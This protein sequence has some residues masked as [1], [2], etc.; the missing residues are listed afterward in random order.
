MIR[1]G[2]LSIFV[3]V[4]LV[5]VGIVGV[6]FAF[7]G[8][9]SVFEE[10]YPENVERVY[11]LV[12]NCLEDSGRQALEKLGGQG[13]E[14]F[15]TILAVEGNEFVP[16][17]FLSSPLLRLNSD[18]GDL[19]FGLALEST[20]IFE[21]CIESIEANFPENLDFDLSEGFSFVSEVNEDHVE[22]KIDG[23]V[24]V[25]DGEIFFEREGIN[26][27][28]D[29]YI[30][31]MVK[32]RDEFLEASGDQVGINLELVAD[33]A[34]KYNFDFRMVADED[35]NILII[36]DSLEGNVPRNFTFGVV[37]E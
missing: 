9:T 22:F 33:L 7:S 16:I 10:S 13:G 4:V 21:G 3:I 26:V 31:N 37:N 5:I 6:F 36:E 11:S 25:S 18:M 14:T 28:I 24:I 27:D 34:D 19:E 8:E 23:N 20:R 17:Y 32:A 35:I 2:Q 12:E 1:R 29:S 30:I 15:R